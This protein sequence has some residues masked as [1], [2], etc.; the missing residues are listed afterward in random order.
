VKPPFT[1]LENL[2]WKIEVTNLEPLEW[3][4]YSKVENINSTW[5]KV[6]IAKQVETLTD[7]I[8]FLLKEKFS[9]KEEKERF[10]P[11]Y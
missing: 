3:S 10:I 11:A 6:E 9:I 7:V 2:K 4:I 5:S 1:A 8:S